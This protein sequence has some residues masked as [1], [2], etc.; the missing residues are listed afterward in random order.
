MCGSFP[1]V[2]STC[3]GMAKNTTIA[4]KRLASLLAAKRDQPYN[5]VLAWLCTQLSSSLLRSAITCLR[6]ARSSSGHAIRDNLLPI[7]L[8]LCEGHIPLS[9]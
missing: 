4:Y 8:A 7:D 3:G 5:V 2:L 1:L 9:Q 6:G